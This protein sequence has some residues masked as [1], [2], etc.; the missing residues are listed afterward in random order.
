LV[1]LVARAGFVATPL[2]AVARVVARRGVA[3][4]ALVGCSSLWLS[5]IGLYPVLRLLPN[6]YPAGRTAKCS[7][8]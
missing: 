1:A 7:L 5:T 3:A 2:V 6:A 4:V 8:W